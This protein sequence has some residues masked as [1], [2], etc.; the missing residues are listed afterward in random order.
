MAEQPG[1]EAGTPEGRPKWASLGVLNPERTEQGT[2]Q[3][4]KLGARATPW[5]QS[6][7]RGQ[8]P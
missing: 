6:E 4:L 8:T 1:M 3:G 2:G 7:A 5:C